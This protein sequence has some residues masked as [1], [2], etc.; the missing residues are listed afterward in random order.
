MSKVLSLKNQIR[1]S[2]AKSDSQS[3]ATGTFNTLRPTDPILEEDL[4]RRESK[5]TT[6]KLN[7]LT[8]RSHDKGFMDIFPKFDSQSNLNHYFLGKS[9]Q[10]LDTTILSSMHDK[11]SDAG[12]VSF[13]LAVINDTLSSPA[14]PSKVPS[15]FIKQSALKEQLAKSM[16]S[17][18]SSRAIPKHVD[19]P[20]S[21]KVTKAELGLLSM[22]NL[23]LTQGYFD[24][25]F[26]SKR[27][28]TDYY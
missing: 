15:C 7:Y 19:I 2:I 9:N 20:G 13:Q 23:S 17:S 5:S 27:I 24:I 1:S 16:L 25:G 3:E 21:I 26:K 4:R 10:R 22:N 14:K 6:S 28:K 18:R 11:E 8:S 12:H